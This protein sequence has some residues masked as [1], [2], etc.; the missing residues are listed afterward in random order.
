M[1]DGELAYLD[2]CDIGDCV[3]C[4][5]R[6]RRSTMLESIDGVDCGLVLLGWG[7][8]C[9][10]YGLALWVLF[11]FGKVLSLMCDSVVEL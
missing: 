1:V 8:G 3:R 11:S 6:W 7:R 9:R 2:N 10:R 4:S 5:S